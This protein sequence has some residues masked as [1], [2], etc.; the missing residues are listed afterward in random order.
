MENL[1]IEGTDTVP[2][3]TLS[4]EGKLKIE[5]RALIED[6][7]KFFRPILTWVREFAADDLQIDINLEYFNTSVSK[8]LHD[9]FQTIQDNPNNK[10]INLNWHYEEGDDE[11]LESGEIYEDLFPRIKFSYHQYDEIL[12]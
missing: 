9:F 12:D 3:V 10:K 11:M 2:T 5:G 7:Y 4:T 6:A 8:Q 1:F